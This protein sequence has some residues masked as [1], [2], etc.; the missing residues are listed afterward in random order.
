[1]GEKS[2]SRLSRSRIFKPVTCLLQSLFRTVL[3]LLNGWSLVTGAVH[4][5]AVGVPGLA[6]TPFSSPAIVRQVN[7][8]SGIVLVE[9][10]R[11]IWDHKEGDEGAEHSEAR[12]DQESS[13]VTL[14]RGAGIGVQDG[15]EDLSANGG[16]GLGAGGDEA[17]HLSTDGRREAL[18]GSQNDSTGSH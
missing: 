16:T 8:P 3:V 6:V 17:H 7:F 9:T 14:A 11:H 13:L 15:C 1:M 2:V 5:N 18:G 12:S 10:A 4:D